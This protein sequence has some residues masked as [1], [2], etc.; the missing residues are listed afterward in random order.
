[1][2]LYDQ[3][4]VWVVSGKITCLWQVW[5]LNTAHFV[6]P[7]PL[8]MVRH[9][10]GTKLAMINHCQLLSTTILLVCSGRLVQIRYNI[11]IIYTFD[12]LLCVSNCATHNTNLMINWYLFEPTAAFSVHICDTTQLLVSIAVLVTL[13]CSDLISLLSYRICFSLITASLQCSITSRL[14]NVLSKWDT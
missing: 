9:E 6:A 10:T 4:S 5:S 14:L 8:V 1:M 12:T 7:V 2:G 3:C 13:V 11:Y